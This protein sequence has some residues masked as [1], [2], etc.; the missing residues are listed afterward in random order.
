MESAIT[1]VIAAMNKTLAE[2]LELKNF[3]ETIE[4]AELD[5]NT[6][7]EFAVLVVGAP[8]KRLYGQWKAYENIMKLP[9]QLQVSIQDTL[10]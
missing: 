10:R 9:E 8:S 4:K 7:A 6:L 2:T 1:N 5:A 3:K